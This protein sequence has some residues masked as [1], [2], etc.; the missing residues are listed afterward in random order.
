MVKKGIIDISRIQVSAL[1][2]LSSS[3]VTLDEL[4]ILSESSF[5]HFLIGNDES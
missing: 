4:L 5:P 1:V 3:T 2:L